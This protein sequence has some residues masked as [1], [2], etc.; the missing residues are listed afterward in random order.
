V[1]MG[2]DGDTPRP[3]EGVEHSTLTVA[4][5]KR[6]GDS[7]VPFVRGMTQD[8]VIA[9]RSLDDVLALHPGPAADVPYPSV[10]DCLVSTFRHLAPPPSSVEKDSDGL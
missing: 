7:F 2:I 6:I 1:H 5:A 4:L 8:T 10:V 3:W 9:G